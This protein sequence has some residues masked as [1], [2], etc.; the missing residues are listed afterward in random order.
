MILIKLLE[1]GIQFLVLGVT[2]TFLAQFSV[3]KGIG[4]DF[5]LL[6]VI[7]LFQVIINLIPTKI[8]QA[9]DQLGEDVLY[10]LV[11]LLDVTFTFKKMVL[12]C[13]TMDS[14]R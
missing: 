1:L 5:L 9:Q 6:Q 13:S 8:S 2:Q 3:A 7:A 12:P 10:I 14:S 11:I 4:H